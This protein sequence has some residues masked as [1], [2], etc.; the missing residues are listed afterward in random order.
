MKS[1]ALR[2]KESATDKTVFFNGQTS[3]QAFFQPSTQAA[4]SVQ[5]KLS[6]SAPGDKFER[7]ADHSAD[8]F[9]NSA[10]DISH[11]A[12]PMNST[13]QT[14]C[15]EC[16]QDATLARSVFGS[17]ARSSG[18]S[19]ADHAAAAVA[20]N[21]SPLPASIRRPYE[22]HFQRDL[23]AVRLHTDKQAHH[24]AESINARAFTL[25]NHIGFGAGE[26]APH[27]RRGQHLLAH[28]L[29]HTIQQSGGNTLR[30]YSTTDCDETSR[31]TIRAR[32]RHAKAMLNNAIARLTA[33]PVTAETQRLFANHFGGWA[34]WRRDIVVSHLRRD[35]EIFGDDDLQYQCETDDDCRAYTYWVFGDVHLCPNWLND[36]SLNEQAETLIH[37]LHHWDGLRGHLDLGYHVNGED[38]ETSWPIAVNNADAYSELAQDL[39]ERP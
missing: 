19:G 17:S 9:V 16:E 36:S 31:A 3:R 35:L 8:A 6:L 38:A 26:Y 20:S 23:S 34:E 22:K 15:A 21:G 24:G 27:T 33:D 4:T 25:G 10:P 30:R 5:A 13:V 14:Q 39:F 7:E 11:S 18:R 2:K 12:A 1:R 29:T 37:E 32:V 28:E